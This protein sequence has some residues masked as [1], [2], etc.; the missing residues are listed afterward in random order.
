MSIVM[1]I[2]SVSFRAYLSD[3]SSQEVNTPAELPGPMEMDHLEEP[4]ILAQIITKTD[5]I[6]SVIE[7]CMEKRGVF[8]HQSYLS[9]DRVEIGFEL[10]LVEIVSDFYDKLKSISRGYASFDYDLIDYRSGD[11]VRLD[12]LLNKDKVDALSVDYSS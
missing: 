7:L 1:T 4:F 11:L 8:K 6:G 9:I 12:V 5:F 2:P 3:G 10:P